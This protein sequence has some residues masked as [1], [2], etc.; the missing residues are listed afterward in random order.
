MFTREKI[1]TTFNAYK[2]FKSKILF[3]KINYK[4]YNL[5]VYDL[6]WLILNESSFMHFYR[7]KFANTSYVSFCR[8]LSTTVLF[9]L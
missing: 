3:Y 4:M 5:F 9:D 7:N 1:L 6:L 2:S 8:V